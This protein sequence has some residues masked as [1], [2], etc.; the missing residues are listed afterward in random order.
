MGGRGG[1]TGE[2]SGIADIDEPQDHLQRFDELAARYRPTLDAEAAGG[3][4]LRDLVGS[5]IVSAVRQGSGVHPHQR[6]D[7]SIDSLIYH[8]PMIDI[9][10]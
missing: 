8:G 2:R 3:P 1:V 9:D 6:F 4:P 5:G 10:R 7:A